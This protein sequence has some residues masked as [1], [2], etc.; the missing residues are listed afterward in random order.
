[1]KSTIFGM[2]I[3]ALLVFVCTVA[4]AEEPSVIYRGRR[5]TPDNRFEYRDFVPSSTDVE[6]L[7]RQPEKITAKVEKSEEEVE[8]SLYTLS[9][10]HGVF[11]FPMEKLIPVFTEYE[12][13]HEI[14][15]RML[16][17]KDLSPDKGPME[18]HFQ[19]V[20]TGFKFFG[21]GTEQHY[22]LYKKPKRLSENEFLIKWNLAE[23]VDGEFYL[24]Y[25]SWYL[26]QLPPKASD[27]TPRTYL[28]NYAVIGYVDPPKGI[29]LAYK[30]FL[31][32]EMR[33]F[34]KDVYDAA[35]DEGF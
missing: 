28:R 2:R 17:T 20:K 34:F 1:M 8:G 21:V 9:D 30:L 32:R 33:S 16:Y 24:Y 27:S 23:S 25:G 10:F 5:I 7:T 15:T 13:E 29:K 3:C 18:P 31:E 19:E 4:G 26:R 6:K 11:P 14:Y 35:A 12:N 22:I